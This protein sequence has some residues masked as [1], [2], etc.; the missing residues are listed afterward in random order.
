MQIYA[1]DLEDLKPTDISEAVNKC[2][3]PKKFSDAGSHIMEVIHSLPNLFNGVD[4]GEVVIYIGRS[5]FNPDK[6]KAGVYGRFMEHFRIKGHH[7]SV[8]AL[9]CDTKV[10]PLWERA[11]IRII[12]KLKQKKRLCVSDIVN[13]AQC[14]AGA[15]P[16]Y[17]ESVI[18]ITWTHGKK[19]PIQHLNTKEI[20]L[21]SNEIYEDLNNEIP[22]IQISDVLSATTDVSQCVEIVWHPRYQI[23][24]NS[25]DIDS[26]GQLTVSSAIIE[27]TAESIKDITGCSLRK[28]KQILMKT[29]GN[30]LVRNAFSDYWPDS[31]YVEDD[32]DTDTEYAED[33]DSIGQLTVSSAIIEDMAESIKDITGCSLRKV[34]QILMNTRGNTLVRNAFS[35]YWPDSEYVEDDT[36][37]E[38]AED[39][40]SIGQ[41]TVSS[42]IIEDMAESIKDIT[43]CSLRKIE[44]ILMNTHGNT[45]V[46]NAFS[47]YW[48]ED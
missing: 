41:L 17:K 11:A 39:I 2:H 22:R 3:R 42:A 26:I 21:V 15:L 8:I 38:C 28:V 27:D 7:Y 35:D 36:D 18:Y 43:G 14:Q 4:L 45:L 40:E 29:R 34:K 46:K 48:P 10:V 5:F 12:S 6:P 32:T 13:I 19:T 44:Q 30:T 47:G 33:I 16:A 23:T 1:L 25:E 37:T 20:N 9:R 31:E 24:D